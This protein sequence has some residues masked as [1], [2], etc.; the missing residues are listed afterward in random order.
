LCEG[1][2]DIPVETHFKMQQIVQKHV[3]NAVSK[4]INLPND[5]PIDNLSEVWLKNLDTLKGTTF[6]RW[7]SRENEPF[8]PVLLHDIDLV[9]AETPEELIRRKERTEESNAMDCVGGAC[10]IPSANVNY[11]KTIV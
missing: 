8:E 6:Y 7:G 2:A 5:Y 4:T 9:I 3:D 1:A 10:E 11:E